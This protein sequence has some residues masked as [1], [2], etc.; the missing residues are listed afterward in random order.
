MSKTDMAAAGIGQG[1]LMLS[2]LHLALIASSVANGGVMMKPVLV[3]RVVSP[4]GTAIKANKPEELYRVM[5]KE[6]ANEVGHMMQ[7]AVSEGTGKKAAVG[8]VKVAGK[9]GTAQ[10]ELSTK[11]NG[12]EHAWF[13]GYAPADNPV[14][15]I[16]VI[17]EYEGRT[18][19][20][21]AAPIAGKMI[22]EYLK[23]LK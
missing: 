14:I 5:D 16:S 20:T 4:K 23:S 3:N 9:T 8:G 7:L 13:V 11:Q 6:I 17:L 15:A 18:G 22:G 10:N 19:G 12:R 1:K 2:P 21:A